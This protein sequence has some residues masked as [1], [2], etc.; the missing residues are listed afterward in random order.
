MLSVLKPKDP[1]LDFVFI[2]DNQEY[3]MHLIFDDLFKPFI[4]ALPCSVVA[5]A[6]CRDGYL[7]VLISVLA[8]KF[9]SRLLMR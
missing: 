7:A 3:A 8:D 4:I 9:N 5:F 2:I 6:D 1:N